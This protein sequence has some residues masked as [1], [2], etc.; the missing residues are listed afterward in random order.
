MIT[1]VRISEEVD[2]TDVSKSVHFIV[3]NS[4]GQEF[5]ARATK[6]TIHDILSQIETQREEKELNRVNTEDIREDSKNFS[7]YEEDVDQI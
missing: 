2:L 3:F 5:K 6:D 4:D 1:L 7:V